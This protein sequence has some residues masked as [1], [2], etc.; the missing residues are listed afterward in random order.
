MKTTALMLLIA[1]CSFDTHA[2]DYCVTEAA[3]K[4]LADAAK[5]SFL[6]KCTR[7]TIAASKVACDR[8]AANKKLAGAAKATFTRQCIAEMTPDVR[9]TCETMADDRKLVG[10]AREDDITQCMKDFVGP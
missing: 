3:G 5:K 7:D 8:Q 9:A 1:L 10:V 2:A 4:G 6:E